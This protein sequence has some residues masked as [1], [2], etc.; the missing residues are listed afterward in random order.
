MCSS[1]LDGAYL[2]AMIGSIALI[3]P[4]TAI[5][6]GLSAVQYNS[7]VFLPPTEFVML[8]LVVLGAF[9]VLAATF[10]MLAFCIGMVL[11]S[12]VAS[13]ADWRLL[14]GLI[15]AVVTPSMLAVGFRHIRR[16]AAVSG[17]DWWQ[18]AIDLGVAPL[19]AG[20]QIGRAHV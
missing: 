5:V 14:L 16:T 12:N 3:V 2:R 7:G 6:L 10:G 4:F 9:D 8:S 13:A 18:R 15:A 11:T 17:A 20:G 1:D 19:L